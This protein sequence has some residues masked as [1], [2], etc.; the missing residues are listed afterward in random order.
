MTDSFLITVILIIGIC[1]V[2]SKIAQRHVDRSYFQVPLTCELTRVGKRPLMRS[3]TPG[4]NILKVRFPN[5]HQT[6]YSVNFWG[7]QHTPIVVCGR[8]GSEDEKLIFRDEYHI[9]HSNIKKDKSDPSFKTNIPGLVKHK[10]K[11]DGS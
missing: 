2:L 10:T 6:D 1:Y 11:S 4:L 7:W 5:I 9:F 3:L 8:S